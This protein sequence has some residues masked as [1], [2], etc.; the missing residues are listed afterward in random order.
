MIGELVFGKTKEVSS[1]LSAYQP[2]SDVQEL[3]KLAKQTY[4]KGDYIL[5]K[6]WVEL[7]NYSVIGRMNKDQRAFNSYVD[8]AMDDP[9]E[10]WKW[11]GTRGMA[12]N[13]VMTMHAHTTASIAVPM[14]FAQNEKQ[15][16]DRNMSGVMRDI[17]EWMSVNSEYR[18][19][20]LLAN[21][22]ALVNPVTFLGAEYAEVMQT[23]KEKTEAGGYETKEI[24]DEV[25]S[26]FKCPV[27]SA[28]QVLITN[29]H[30]P[31]IQKQSSIIKKDY[32]DYSAAQAKYGTHDNWRL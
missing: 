20:Y 27:Y 18:S 1:P 5:N 12:R 4:E 15:E 32:I 11:K 7:N 19:S 2:G 23:V 22:G 17:L 9:N 24:L 14:A 6:P 29:A 30:E 25:F 26:G 8:E 16:E 10:A 21:M 31:N 13:K 3:T 28:D